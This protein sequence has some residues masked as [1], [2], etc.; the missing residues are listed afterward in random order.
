[1]SRHY[2]LA[3]LT[4]IVAFNYTDRFAFGIVLQDIKSDLHLTD[5]QLGILSGMAFAALYSTM[6]LPIARWADR[7]NR[8]AIIS[9]ATGIWSIAVAACALARGYAQLALM[10]VVVGVG[11]AGCVPPS[12]SLIADFFPRTERARAV[13]IYM[14]GITASLV[15]GYLASGWL[16]QMLGWRVTFLIIGLPGCLLATIART[17]LREPRAVRGAQQRVSPVPL[18]EAVRTL[19]ANR[20]FRHL[21][22]A[23]AAMWF[24][25]YGTMQWTPAFMVREFGVSTGEL[26]TWFAALYGIGGVLGTY[27]GGELAMRCAKDNERLQLRAMACV[28]AL[29]AIVNGLAYLP[30]AAPNAGFAYAWLGL[31]YWLGALTNGPLFAVLQGLVPAT[32]RA[33]ATAVIY[34][35]ANLIG[36][37]LGPWLAGTLSDHLQPQL[38]AESLRYAMLIMCPGM[39]WG[40][41]HL[42][43]ASASV[44]RDTLEATAG[45][46]SE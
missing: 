42:L 3:V 8:I 5:S 25:S 46:S 7:G 43:A 27:L 4:V 23:N 1:M 30:A 31:S 29:S 14:Q 10:R 33:T 12:L 11:E 28:I 34:L 22:L 21:L 41:W 24:I 37:G 16:N 19:A 17:T 9:L 18:G 20:T 35:F 32:I 36:I 45:A 13:S 15:I 38:G 6:G 39:L 44:T 26:G 2:L 40:A